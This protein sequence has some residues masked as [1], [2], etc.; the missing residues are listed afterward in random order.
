MRASA[1]VLS[2]SMFFILALTG[3]K[4]ERSDFFLGGQERVK[5]LGWKKGVLWEGQEGGHRTSL[6]ARG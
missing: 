6:L 3:E 4:K 1:P 2:W 5:L